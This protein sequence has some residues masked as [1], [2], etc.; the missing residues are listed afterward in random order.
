MKSVV[1][2]A[3][4]ESGRGD[5]F[6]IDTAAVLDADST[7][8]T[9]WPEE[10]AALGVVFSAAKLAGVAATTLGDTPESP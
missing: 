7:S 6:G 5:R 10:V 9:P 4:D 2:N 8:T 3:G 1:A